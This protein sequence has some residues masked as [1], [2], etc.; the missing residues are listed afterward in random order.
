MRSIAS[1]PDRCPATENDQ[2]SPKAAPPLEAVV[3]ER[4]AQ[5]RI[6]I[7]AFIRTWDRDRPCVEEKA[8]TGG[9]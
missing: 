8:V 3:D 1:P 4:F 7:A 9:R 5:N 6:N 2:A